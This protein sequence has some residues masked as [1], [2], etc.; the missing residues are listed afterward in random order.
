ML[1]TVQE[2]LDHVG[3]ETSRCGQGKSWG[4][5]SLPV[6]TKSAPLLLGGMNL[7]FF[8]CPFL[9]VRA[10]LLYSGGSLMEKISGIGDRCS[11]HIH[12]KDGRRSQ[13]Y[14]CG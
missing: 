4:S 5:S 1:C 14:L 8:Y 2:Q 10:L 6:P 13:H 9:H 7:T 12:L 3:A 11:P